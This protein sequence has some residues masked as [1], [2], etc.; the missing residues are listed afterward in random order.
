MRATSA[1]ATAPHHAGDPTILQTLAEH[2]GHLFGPLRLFTSYLFLAGTAGAL[3]VV[4]TFWALP[5]FWHQLPRDQGRAHAVD[6]DKSVGKPLSGGVIFV[7][8]FG[9]LSDRIGRRR[10]RL[11]QILPQHDLIQQHHGHDGIIP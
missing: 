1:G 4:A 3:A 5:R 10:H 11:I 2:Y 7:P 9:V 6:A 8:I